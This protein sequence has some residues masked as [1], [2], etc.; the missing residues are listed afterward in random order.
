MV[1]K[2]KNLSELVASKIKDYILEKTLSTG[3]RLPTEQ[4]FAELFGVSR[5]CIREATKAL[6]FLGIIH[7]A[8]K[9][10]LTVG[11]VNMQRVTDY[12]G[13]HLAL[14]NYPREQLLKT[15]LVLEIGA[16]SESSQNLA[17]DADLVKKLLAINNELKKAQTP[18]EFIRGDVAFHQALLE[19]SHIEPLIA[20]NELMQV[21]FRRFQEEVSKG[22]WRSGITQHEQ[23]VQWLQEG[24]VTEAERILRSHLEYYRE[25]AKKNESK[26]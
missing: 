26:T 15:R 4:E 5:T 20:F 9:Q 23:I 3:D 17:K 8:P 12:L 14:N 25:S 19:A 24:K 2:K 13:F 18:A 21:F 16:M 11:K 6:G 1:L 10:G 22:Q 7:S